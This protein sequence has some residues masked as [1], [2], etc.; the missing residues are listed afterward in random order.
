MEPDA[1]RAR[2][3][4]PSEEVARTIAHYNL[5]ALPVVDESDHLLG[6]VTVDDAIDVIL[7]EEWQHR[8]PK[9]FR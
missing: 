7:P 3:T 1:I 4:D 9:L 2:V 5:L 6:V 8:L